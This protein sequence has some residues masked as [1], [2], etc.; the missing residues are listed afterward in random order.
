MKFIAIVVLALIAVVSCDPVQISDN[1]VGDI[2]T[3]GISAKADIVNKVDWDIVNVI[4]GL[5]NQNADISR[6]A[7]PLAAE[8]SGFSVGESE[9]AE[10]E[11]LEEAEVSE[12][13]VG[14]P[15][16]VEFDGIEVG[17]PSFAYRS[18]EEA[19]ESEI[20]VGEPS[21]TYK[22]FDETE[23]SEIETGESEIVEIDATYIIGDSPPAQ[24]MEVPTEMEL[25]G[26]SPP[27]EYLEAQYLEIPTEMELIGD[28]P[29]AEHLEAP[30]TSYFIGDSPPAQFL[31]V[32]T[33][34]VLIGDSPPI[35]D[36]D[37]TEGFISQE[38]RD[39]FVQVLPSGIQL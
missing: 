30:M 12:I 27:A 35:E 8:E 39:H 1:N 16:M 14:E 31:E 11:P 24:Y 36:L 18:F 2:I 33:E 3:V 4:V 23:E 32:P 15:E 19:E 38:A 26:D 20:E 7:A 9:V 34:M 37:V 21:F 25:I 17:E 5:L 10:F 13:E 28:S 22:S 6:S 29:P